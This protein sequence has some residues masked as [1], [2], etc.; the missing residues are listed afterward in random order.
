M[1]LVDE[2]YKLDRLHQLIR[3]QN[4]DSTNKLAEKMQ[5]SRRTALRLIDILKKEVGC[6]I[7]FNK[8]KNSY[9]YEYPIKLII[10]KFEDNNS[11]NE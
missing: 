10:F 4:T 6:P 9:C 7:Y 8:Y 11:D 3:L 2:M 1:N 5:V